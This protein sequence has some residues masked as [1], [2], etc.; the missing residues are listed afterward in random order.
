MHECTHEFA[1]SPFM[2]PQNL[3]VE[4]RSTL[5]SMK[6]DSLRVCVC[7]GG[8]CD[9]NDDSQLLQQI[10]FVVTVATKEAGKY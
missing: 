5:T 6:Y 7:V 2:L 10:F 8:A 9:G 3:S 1:E 4:D